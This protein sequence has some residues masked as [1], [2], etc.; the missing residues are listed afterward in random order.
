MLFCLLLHVMRQQCTFLVP[1]ACSSLRLKSALYGKTMQAW[2]RTVLWSFTRNVVIVCL[3]NLCVCF[4]SSLL[5]C[6][7]EVLEFSGSNQEKHLCLVWYWYNSFSHKTSAMSLLFNP[8]PII[9]AANTLS[10]LVERQGRIQTL[11]LIFHF[12]IYYLQTLESNT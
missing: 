10:G 4:W 8:F 7:W 12:E 11:K 9:S 5:S 1:V 3:L 6:K 2:V